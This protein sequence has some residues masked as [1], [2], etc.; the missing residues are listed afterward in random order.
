MDDKDKVEL[1]ER[2]I[3]A[4]TGAEEIRV[5]DHTRF[6]G[7]EHMHGYVELVGA[8]P[9]HVKINGFDEGLDISYTSE[10]FEDK[11]LF[12]DKKFYNSRI[13]VE[14]FYGLDPYK[15]IT[16]LKNEIRDLKIPYVL[17]EKRK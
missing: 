8:S 13:V 10:V 16:E 14:I 15:K 2:L 5:T 7:A 3:K 9:E 6:T 12:T 17:E 1:Y 4:L 11:D